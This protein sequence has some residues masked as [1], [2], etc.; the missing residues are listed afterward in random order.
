MML[1]SSSTPVLGSLL[2]SFSD[3]PN[4]NQHHSEYL[5]GSTHKHTPNGKI[6]C[7]NNGG[8]QNVRKSSL[9]RSHSVAEIKKCASGNGFRRV[10]SEGNLEELGDDSSPYSVDGLSLAKKSSRRNSFCALEAIPSFSFSHSRTPYLE[11]EEDD[12]DD[13]VFVEEEELESESVSNALSADKD[14]VF[15]PVGND[16][17]NDYGNLRFEGGEGKMYLATG[18]G[19]S[20]IDFVDGCG[21]DSGG[22]GRGSYRP[23]DLGKDG[24][25]ENDSLGMEEYYKKMVEENPG[26]PLFLRNY[27][28]FLYQKKM[29]LEGAEEYYSRAILADPEDGEI[30]SQ[31][32]KLTWELH[33]DRER[34]ANYFKRAIQASSENSHIHAAYAC[35]LW[36]AEEDEDEEDELAGN[37]RT[38][39]QLFFQHASAT[40]Y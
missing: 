9:F 35:F 23:V 16:V 5:H 3:S 22:G 12:S 33:R 29:D 2:P 6:S 34:A 30:L 40:A 11:E 13:D 10:L 26:N 36:D 27:A 21:S 19:I 24:G 37:S 18:L 17:S 20:G 31:Y 1:R 25:G 39:Q 32:A 15:G 38:E 14:S 28:Q 8:S 4:N 7:N